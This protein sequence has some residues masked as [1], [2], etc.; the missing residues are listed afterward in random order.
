[1]LRTFIDSAQ[2][3]PV[4][5]AWAQTAL[6]DDPEGLRRFDGEL[7]RR[8]NES[9]EG[10][11]AVLKSMAKQTVP[12]AAASH[13]L[14][15]FQR[16]GRAVSRLEPARGTLADAGIE[17][18]P[19]ALLS[20]GGALTI[21]KPGN[22]WDRPHG[23]WGVLNEQGGW[24]HTENGETPWF[25]VELPHFGNLSGIVLESV[26][27]QLHRAKG[28]RILVSD[29]GEDWRPVGSLETASQ[30]YR[31]DL[32]ETR[33]QGRFV[34]FERDGKCLHFFRVLIYGERAS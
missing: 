6:K 16:I 30:W 17:A 32:S 5:V 19:G 2:L 1:M 22:R 3:G 21:F 10:G 14:D 24:F 25:E 26:P 29:D 28:V 18:F 33:P 13:D 23:H 34:R 8:T 9:S 7:L 11:D 15:T 27:G 4:Q 31:V 20:S 12:T